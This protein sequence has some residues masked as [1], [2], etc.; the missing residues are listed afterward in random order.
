MNSA[1]LVR[2]PGR[3]DHFVQL[4]KE[5]DE[6]AD[7]VAEYVGAGLQR[8]EAAIVIATRQHRAAFLGRLASTDR[9]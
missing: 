8:G 1:E 6:L 2:N 4:Y 3:H 9:G 7:A 5:V